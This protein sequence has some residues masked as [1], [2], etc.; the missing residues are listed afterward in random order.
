MTD[1]GTATVQNTGSVDGGFDNME[2]TDRALLIEKATGEII[3][4]F[5]KSVLME[6]KYEKKALVG[7][8]S[9]RFEHVGSIGAYY[10]NAG[11]HVKGLNVGHDK[12]E[13][14]LDRPIVS[15]FFT[16]DFQESMAHYDSRKEYTRKMGEVLAQKYDRNIQMKFITA[17]RL[18]NVMSEYA[19]GSVIVDAGLASADLA[20]KVNAFAKA[21]ITGRKELIKKNVKGTIF[22]I[23]DPDTYFEVVENRT[24]LNKDFGNV[25]DYAEGE[26][27][28]IGGVPLSYHNYIPQSDGTDVANT[29]FYDE[30]H[31]IN[32]TG[33]VAFMG[34]K[35]SVAVLRGGNISTKIWDD[36]GRMGTWTRA[37]LACGMGV[38]R[39]E[40][41]IE[42]RK[43]ALPANWGQIIFDRNRVGSGKLPA[44]SF[45]A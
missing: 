38:M 28:R 18:K 20:V 30:Y 33:T 11:E 24:L 36:N 14:T 13:L 10:H 32:C 29:E 23:T 19:G 43:S 31:G 26:V 6:G 34:T 9:L 41:A 15:S 8:K 17:S 16:D 25:G 39:P 35:E 27:F 5:D 7:G 4:S 37:S 2:A 42:I 45:T 40:C 12:S 21:L 3:A 1:L 22:A 44:G